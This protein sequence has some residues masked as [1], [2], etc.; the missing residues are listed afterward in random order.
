M[1]KIILSISITFILILSLYVYSQENSLTGE[2]IMKKVDENA[3]YEKIEYRGKMIIKKGDKS[4]FKTMHVY[5]EG[6]EKALIE[7]TN[8]GDAGTKY[9]KLSNE[10]WI[11]FPDAEEIVKISGHML[12]ESMMGSDFSYEDMMENEKLLEK[13]DVDVIGSEIVKQAEEERSCYVLELNAK[14]KDVTYAKRKVWVDK[15]RFV[16]LKG[17][18]FALSG[19]L[20]KEMVVNKVQKYDNRYFAT[21]LVMTNKLI[22]DS[23]TVFQMEEIDFDVDFPDRIFS[24]RSLER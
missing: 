17:Q 11:Y 18:L 13:Y 12:R 21:E 6:E 22:D 14:E 9:L 10:L 16:V 15:E 20:L 19:K 3:F 24:K 2:E 4:R 7:F 23:S 5:A 8:P 1:K